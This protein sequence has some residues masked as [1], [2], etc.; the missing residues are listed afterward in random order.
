MTR[1]YGEA[2]RYLLSG[3]AS[4]TASLLIPFLLREGLGIAE[5]VAVGISLCV[6]FLLNFFTT[7]I[8]VFRSKGDSRGE[9]AR[10]ALM[11]LAFRGTEYAA[12]LVLNVVFGVQYLLAL[13]SVLCVSFCA[14]F[15]AQR[16]FVYR[17]LA[18]E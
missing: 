15:V 7:R 6:V 13:A 9:M 8:F 16:R 1:L 4:A 5:T 2:W 18:S 17:I 3:V 14:K 10:F 12:F 11:S